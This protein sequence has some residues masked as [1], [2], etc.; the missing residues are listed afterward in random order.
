M[1]EGIDF[2]AAFNASMGAAAVETRAA[3][4]D[5]ASIKTMLRLD[6]E[7]F[8]DFFIHQELVN[9]VPEFHKEIWGLLTD[10]GKERILLAIPRGHNKTTLAKLNIV[11]HFLFTRH[12]FCVYL[13]NTNN[14]AKNAV[15]DVLAYMQSDN[16]RAVFGDIDI[17][18]SSETDS[19]WQFRLPMGNGQWKT[20]IIR[21]VGAGQQVRGLNIDNQRP[22]LAVI[23]DVEDL[24]NTDS[25]TLQAKLDRWMFGPFLKALAKNR[26]KVIW[27]GNMLKKTSLLARLSRNP[28]WNPVV[29]GSLVQ[30]TQT[31]ELSPLW[32]DLW[33]VE[34]L[35]ADFI[36]H[37]NLGLVESWM[38]EMMNMPGHG[39]NG[40]TE[41]QMFFQPGVTPDALECSWI[42]IDPAFGENSHN[43]KTAIVVHG[44]PEATGIPQVL[45]YYHG[46]CDEVTMYENA[47][48]LA[49]Y[50]NAWLWGIEAV[51]AQKVLITLFTLLSQNKMI[52]GIEFVPLMAGKGDPKVARIKA[53]VALMATENYALSE[54]D[55]E[56]VNQ[57]MEY[58]MKKKSN[59]DDLI[60]AIAYGPQLMDN[61][62]SVIR[63]LFNGGA[64]NQ[65]AAKYS[66]EVESV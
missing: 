40:F 56:S 34:E 51:A 52:E 44:I 21:A 11:W 2:D 13:S 31:D 50:W 57:Y 8:M 66:T 15:K 6:A 10:A 63:E 17:F 47:L 37:K 46:K 58:N 35:K 28:A 9:P 30:N 4:A 39:E 62:L 12:R 42:T 33:T 5:A 29:F 14:I 54:G 59:K 65:I 32:P 7:F 22:D 61:Y 19:L 49:Q 16:F 45:A 36:E 48:Q 25:E 41:D 18:K 3:I 23:D 26:R 1:A 55:V 60:D 38:C 43:D 64:L 27:L 53:F 20:C 24:E